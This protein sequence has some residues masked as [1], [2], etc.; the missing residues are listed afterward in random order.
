M[1]FEVEQ[2]LEV[3]EQTPGVLEALLRRKSSAWLNCRI[4]P[5]TFSPLDVLGHLIY[6]E[7]T[8]WIPRARI[9]LE[10]R[11]ARAFDPFDRFAFGP[12]I[13]GQS[14][15]QLLDRFAELRRQNLAEL[16]G[17]ALDQEQMDW[18]GLHPALGTVTLHQLLATWAVHDLNHISQVVRVM[19][20]EYTEA[21]GPW[22][23][24][25]SILK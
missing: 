25:L 5:D 15:A 23:E 2:A 21:V 17:F 6:G 19:A 11:D 8:D 20:N 9:I 14:V 7:M 24:Y 22:R 3:L 1:Q 16:R 13:E 10:C 4:K 18:K 12:L